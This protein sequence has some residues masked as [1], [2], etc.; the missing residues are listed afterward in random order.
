MLLLFP[1]RLSKHRRKVPA[2]SCRD[3]NS[4]IELT[5]AVGISGNCLRPTAGNNANQ[6][7]YTHWR[8]IDAP[9][10]P[11]PKAKSAYIVAIPRNHI[12]QNCNNK[13]VSTAASVPREHKECQM[14]MFAERHPFFLWPG[15]AEPSMANTVQMNPRFET[16]RRNAISRA[17]YVVNIFANVRWNLA[18][19]V[20][21]FWW[22]GAGTQRKRAFPIRMV[23]L[24]IWREGEKDWERSCSAVL[25]LL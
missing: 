17:L 19:R 15:S 9:S 20:F 16:R 25:Y 14:T 2:Y 11:F 1:I 24:L 23:F 6:I 18:A 7:H 13:Q 21:F 8:K 5:V 10:P 12:R 4:E 3:N 22:V